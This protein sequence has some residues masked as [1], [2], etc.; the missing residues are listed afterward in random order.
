M[1]FFMKLSHQVTQMS[2]PDE[3][4]LAENLRIKIVEMVLEFHS[5][6]GADSKRIATDFA[7]INNF[8]KNGTIPKKEEYPG[9]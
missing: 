3:K 2:D 9:G 6:K 1:G 7:L 8:I 4:Q 5:D